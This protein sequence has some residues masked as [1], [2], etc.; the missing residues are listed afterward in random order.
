MANTSSTK[1]T[2]GFQGSETRRP[3]DA[4]HSA[5]EKVQDA[6]SKLAGA[7][8]DAASAVTRGAGDV[9]GLASRKADDAASSVGSGMKSAAGYLREKAPQEG[10]LGSAA[11]TAA[12]TLESGGRY[13]QEEGFTGMMEDVTNMIRRNPWPAL[14]LGVG[15]GFLLARTL[16]SRS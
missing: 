4:A 13:L 12:N 11:S 6:G 14:F 7:A 5:A 15:L 1:G 16:S 9:A 3:E 2:S 10:M 8:Q